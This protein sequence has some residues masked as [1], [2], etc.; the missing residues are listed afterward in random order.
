MTDFG[1]VG[2]IYR[3]VL[4]KVKDSGYSHLRVSNEHVLYNDGHVKRAVTLLIEAKQDSVD[5]IY[6]RI[7][8]VNS[9]SKVTG[10][11]VYP[12]KEVRSYLI[13]EEDDSR[14][15]EIFIEPLDS[16]KKSKFNLNIM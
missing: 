3:E 7:P 1:D 15:I 6:W 5:K 14:I 16:E 4:S 11:K 8:K 13:K 9:S 12:N 10:V 2:R